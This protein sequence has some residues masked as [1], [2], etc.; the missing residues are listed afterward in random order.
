MANKRFECKCGASIIFSEFVKVPPAFCGI[1]KQATGLAVVVKKL[2]SVYSGKTS[3]EMRSVA[4]LRL[5]AGI[6]RTG[7][8]LDNDLVLKVSNGRHGEHEANRIEVARWLSAPANIKPYLCPIV[9]WDETNFEWIIMKRAEGF[10]TVT[11][12][13]F[14]A[15]VRSKCGDLHSGNIARLNGRPVITDYV[16]G[17]AGKWC[18]EDWA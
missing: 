3:A 12:N 13:E 15:D 6:D 14:P 1:C 16:G 10:G 7:Y 17:A 9:D 11:R 4:G 5:G 18:R 8:A 2:R